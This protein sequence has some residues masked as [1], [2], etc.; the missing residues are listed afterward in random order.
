[1]TE[2]LPLLLLTYASAV[3]INTLVAAL[4]WQRN[5]DRLHWCLLS[6]WLAALLTFISQ[7]A[8]LP[9]GMVG[10]AVGMI[11][12]FLIT[13]SLAALIIET[14]ELS[15]T[16]L[17]WLKFTLVYLV[18]ISCSAY[19]AMTG[20]SFLTVTLPFIVCGS[21][22]IFWVL[23]KVFN[24]GIFGEMSIAAKGLIYSALA[25]QIHF[26]D[27][28]FL[29]DKP[30]F[31]AP[32]FMLAILIIFSLSIF[33]I[34]AVLQ[35]AVNRQQRISMKL[36]KLND[37]LEQRVNQR[38]VELEDNFAKMQVMQKQ[39]ILQEERE[40][41]VMDMH[42]GIGGQL[43]ATLAMLESK[44]VRLG[45]IKRSVQEAL[46][47]LRLIV[48]AS[49]TV[50]GD[51]S[52]VLGNFRQRLLRTLANSDTQLH[53]Q[54]GDVP[55]IP[56]IGEHDMLQLLRILQEACTNAIKYAKADNIYIST[57]QQQD[58]ILIEIADDGAG[59]QLRD[60]PLGRGLHNMR[61]RAERLGAEFDV[62]ETHPGVAVRLLF[63]A[64]I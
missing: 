30:E 42:D 7:G 9:F 62:V 61:R 38:T 29:R 12:S 18:S 46:D 45:D 60:T 19:F 55:L 8:L 20:H 53:W 1:M 4:L 2:A 37:D 31:A 51:V 14:T 17:P 64:L 48:D 52:L 34:A 44:P 11:P 56:S 58:K 21:L 43:V 25:Y 16:K 22:P 36:D 23:L 63:E 39:Q 15:D 59:M 41:V 24:S 32:G 47:D 5:R 10:R 35:V 54:I 3:A 57:R 50:E 49:D 28:P 27:Y 33:A 13:L 26:L 40:R 6:L